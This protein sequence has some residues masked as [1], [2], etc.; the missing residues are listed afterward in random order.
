MR[1]VTLSLIHFCMLS[2]GCNAYRARVDDVPPCQGQLWLDV[3]RWRA[4]RLPLA[5]RADDARRSQTAGVL[6]SWPQH[7]RRRTEPLLARVNVGAR[8]PSLATLF[9]YLSPA[10]NPFNQWKCC[11]ISVWNPDKCRDVRR[12]NLLAVC[13]KLKRLQEE[14]EPCWPISYLHS[15]F[16]AKGLFSFNCKMIL[17][18]K[19]FYYTTYEPYLTQ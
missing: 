8:W 16:F 18:L 7:S 12:E 10:R 13:G 9:F 6:A 3:S 1:Y 17:Y 4:A 11:I 14:C 19:M 5:A 2:S 15:L